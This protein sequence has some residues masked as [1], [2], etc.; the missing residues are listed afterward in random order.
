VHVDLARA[1]AERAG[2]PLKLIGHPSAG[3]IVAGLASGALD[4]GF[5]TSEQ[6]RTG[7][8]AFTPAYLEIEATYLVPPGSPLAHASEADREGM[9]IAIAAKSAYEHFLLRSLRQ[10]Q[11]ISAPSTHAAFDLF[12]KDRLDALVGLRPRLVLDAALLPGSRVLDGC[13]MTMPQ[14]IAYA[15]GCED[16]AEW[17]RTFVEDAKASGLVARTLAKQGIRT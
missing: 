14:A 15:K 16:A 9:R 4:A 10:A 3:D 2:V 7:E 11:L 6:G 1:L 17:L 12:V 5:I 8:I 13:F